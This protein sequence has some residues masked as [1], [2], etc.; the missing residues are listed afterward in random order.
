MVFAH[1]IRNVDR[2]TL[3]CEME[4]NAEG[5]VVKHEI[6]QSVINTTERMTYSDVN[7]IL[8]EKDEELRQKYETLVPMFELM[9]EFKAFFKING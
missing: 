3:S 8:N 9:E 2:F 5:E 4:L 6:F 1:S 7:K